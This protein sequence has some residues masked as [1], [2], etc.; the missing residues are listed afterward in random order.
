MERLL[1]RFDR[2]ETDLGLLAERWA[3]R[4]LTVSGADG[5]GERG[6]LNAVVQI[7]P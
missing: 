6:T 5:D 7:R 4:N 2:F 1:T 3:A